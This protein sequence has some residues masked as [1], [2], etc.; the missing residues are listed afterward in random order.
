MAYGKAGFCALCG[1]MRRYFSRVGQRDAP[2]RIADSEEGGRLP[3]QTLATFFTSLNYDFITYN[4]QRLYIN[5]DNTMRPI[6][7][8]DPE[9]GDPIFAQA[10]RPDDMIKI[11]YGQL[12]LAFDFFYGKPSV[13]SD[14]LKE[15]GLDAFLNSQGD[16]GKAVKDAQV[17][18]SDL[19]FAILTSKTSYSCGNMFACVMKDAGVRILGER[20]CC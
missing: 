6:K 19:N 16:T 10:D 20:P 11:D 2:A 13:A 12:C 7:D 9:Y 8:R 14:V 3:V 15:Q 5:N 18:Y 17:D 1:R 4:G